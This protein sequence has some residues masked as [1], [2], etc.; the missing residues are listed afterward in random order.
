[1]EQSDVQRGLQQVGRSCLSLTRPW[2]YSSLRFAS[3]CINV[4]MG[5]TERCLP[6]ITA[7]VAGVVIMPVVG[8]GVD[9]VQVA[10]GI[11]NTHEAW[12]EQG[13]DK[14]W[15]EVRLSERLFPRGHPWLPAGIEPSAWSTWSTWREQGREHGCSFTGFQAVGSKPWSSAEIQGLGLSPW[16]RSG[17][18][19][20]STVLLHMSPSLPGAI[21]LSLAPHKNLLPCFVAPAEASGMGQEA[22]WCHHHI[23]VCPGIHKELLQGRGGSGH[24][25]L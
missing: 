5:T 24:Q 14:I 9:S 23:R 7:G 13:N 16:S 10:R 20:C 8:I 2:F 18:Q 15:D 17:S 12:R 11:A 25:L 6:H 19:L 22:R 1:M 3:R 21:S 4:H